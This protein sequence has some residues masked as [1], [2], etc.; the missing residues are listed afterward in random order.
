[1]LYDHT[2]NY[3]TFNPKSVLQIALQAPHLET[4][5]VNLQYA[6]YNM[7]KNH[8]FQLYVKELLSRLRVFEMCTVGVPEMPDLAA[9]EEGVAVNPFTP[10]NLFTLS[11]DLGIFTQR[12]HSWMSE[13][14][15]ANFGHRVT[16]TYP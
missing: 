11:T 8:N 9:W 7:H 14:N 2:Y 3:R 15:A 5:I 10:H 6:S 13:V 1:M 4:L 16:R 12:K